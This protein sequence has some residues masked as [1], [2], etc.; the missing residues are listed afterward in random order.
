M[1]D[2]V[3]K[4]LDA[5]SERFG[6]AIDWSSENILPYLQ[7]LCSKY[8][9]YEFSTS[10]MWLVLGSVLVILG[11]CFVVKG[12]HLHKT[13]IETKSYNDDYVSWYMAAVIFLFIG[14]CV[15]IT[16]INDIITCF[17]F[18]EKLFVQEIKTLLN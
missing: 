10:I 1:A 5:F 6:L 11:I 4:I 3:I 17:T 16:Q 15:D 8:V 2:E 12:K 9:T 18:P 13:S 14:I 7:Q